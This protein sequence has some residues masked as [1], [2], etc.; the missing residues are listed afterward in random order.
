MVTAAIGALVGWAFSGS[1]IAAGIVTTAFGAIALGASLGSLFASHDSMDL[2]SSPNYSFG[3]ISNTMSQ[4]VP[5]YVIYGKCRVAG[6]IIY[7]AFNND[8][9]EVQD[10][11]ILVGEGGVNAITGVM[12]NDQNP[13]ELEGCSVT[14]Y[15]DT[16]AATHDSRDPSGARPYPDNVALIC[17]TLKAQESLNG[18]PTITSIVEGMKVW[19][20]NGFAYSRNPIWIILDILCHPRYGM[21]MGTVD[22]TGAYMHPNWD[23]IDYACALAAA[24]YCDGAVEYG[25]R[26]QLDFVL[27]SSRPIRDVLTDFLAVCRGYMVQTNKLEIYIDAPVSTYSRSITPGN[28][29]ENSFTFWQAADEDV[30]NRIT[31]DWVDPDNNYERVT[32]VFQ[33]SDDIAIRGVVE[34]SVSLLGVTRSGQVGHMGYYLLK[35]SMLVR[36]FCSFGVSFKDCDIQPGEV[37]TVSF[38]DFTG[39][40]NKPFRVLSVKDNGNDVMTVTCSEYIPEIYDDSVMEVPVHIDTSLTTNYKPDDVEDLTIT[41]QLETLQDG[42][43]NLIA[44]ITWTPP[45]SYQTLELWYRYSSEVAWVAGGTLP[46]GSTE[47]YLPCTGNIGDT[48]YVRVYTVS[49]LGVRSAG[50]TTSRILRGD[51]T[52][53]AAPTNLQGEGGFR[54]AH[55]TW[56]DPP[57][58]DL[59]HIDVY[60][61]FTADDA[62]DFTKIG[63]APRF[64]QEYIDNGLGVLQTAW[65]KLKAADVA[66]N[67]SVF[68]D[69]VSATT[70]AIETDDIPDGTIQESHLAPSLAESIERIPEIEEEAQERL[71][72][73]KSVL[74][75]EIKNLREYA[76]EQL[77]SAAEAAIGVLDMVKDVGDKLSDAGV[78]VDPDSGQVKIYGLEVLREETDV[79]LSNAEIRLDAHAAQISSKVT[80]AQVNE[81]IA[82]AVFGDV[83]ELIVSG[84]NARIDEVEETLDA[85]AVAI[86]EKAS[87]TQVADHELRLTTAESDILGL[88]AAI[89]LKA[90]QLEVSE[91]T[92]RVNSA[93]LKID[94]QNGVISQFVGQSEEDMEAL[95]D[96]SIQNAINGFENQKR[97]KESLAYAKQELKATI[98]EVDGKVEAEAAARL[99]LGVQVEENSA[100]LL[101][102]QQVRATRDEAYGSLT[103][104]LVA[105]LDNDAG[106][107]AVE[108]AIQG[109]ENSKALSKQSAA[110]FKE[111]NTRIVAGQ[112]SEAESREVLEASLDG[113]LAQIEQVSKVTAGKPDV[114]NQPSAPSG[115]LKLG[116][117]WIDTNS[118]IHRWTG[119]EWE[120]CRDKELVELM[121]LATAQTWLKAQVSA[122]GKTVLTGIGLLADTTT[123][124]EITMLANRFYLV[125][126]IDG[127][128]IQP[129]AVDASDPSNP[130]VVINGDLFVKALEDNGYTDGTGWIVGG[131][132]A[133]LNRIQLGA[134]GAFIAGA[135]AI[136]QLGGDGQYISIDSEQG[137]I[138]I[139]NTETG[140]YILMD[141]G[142]LTTYKTFSGM[143][144]PVALKSL[145]VLETGVAQNNVRKTLS[146]R[147]AA[148][149]QITVGLN[150][151]AIYAPEYQSSKQR[152][153]CY[154]NDSEIYYNEATGIASFLP[155]CELT[156]EGGTTNVNLGDNALGSAS[157]P[158]S[159]KWIVFD[160]TYTVWDGL[161]QISIGITQLYISVNVY[162]QIGAGSDNGDAA[163]HR[164]YTIYAY[165][166]VNGT[167]YLIGS[168]QYTKAHDTFSVNLTGSPEQYGAY[169]IQGSISIPTT[170][171][172]VSA[173]V[174]LRVYGHGDTYGNALNGTNSPEASSAV[175]GNITAFTQTGVST[176]IDVSGWVNYTAISE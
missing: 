120:E 176:A 1:L 105:Q 102:E 20:P 80:L 169:K 11:Y 12:A 153:K 94:A 146:Q 158:I 28:I 6:N 70:K 52:P 37:L 51:F 123:G 175:L 140:E 145:R 33:D 103:T 74:S 21:G 125:S 44:K 5:I 41:E 19:T 42:S 174:K 68:S 43:Y 134:G 71:E 78:Y 31:V 100:A 104:A 119:S 133:A 124:S 117:L 26:F 27:D 15:T 62:E 25:S 154:V 138:R 92:Q 162:A 143:T 156:T 63:I 85:Q 96:A 149:P 77:S 159:G 40:V 24:N 36:N 75:N 30:C 58:G 86:S 151:V 165:V 55:I 170:E 112:R 126:S 59:D 115:S 67:E 148:R 108:N 161:F 116:D 164:T 155:H 132:I 118:L 157:I 130:K 83:G 89:A 171:N 57:D 173:S 69:V 109:Y 111:L 87:S 38:E 56:T 95:S 39:W 7:Q 18:T 54:L 121:E 166:S 50:Q 10:L 128:L 160:Q 84:I 90:S 127:E 82:E 49:R 48:L 98:A 141:K 131:N 139:S 142:D 22:S 97:N 129:F 88:D 91:L 144:Y 13:A 66:G 172:L 14:T 53:P 34:K 9:K 32:D 23:K 64:A 137:I 35:S 3:P 107:A 135:N 110:Y 8:K 79:R 168:V 106:E 29:T 2:S 113:A 122:G 73:A 47:Y 72:S 16:T 93:E 4:L 60:R 114:Y 163:W 152:V 81:R 101:E 76:D 99:E 136:F 65:Y 46:K 147:F 45:E 17:L 150:D 61:S 167:D